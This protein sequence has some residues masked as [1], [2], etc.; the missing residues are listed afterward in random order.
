[1]STARTDRPLPHSLRKHLRLEKARLRRELPPEAAQRAIE[2]LERSLRRAGE[3]KA[4][5]R[6][7]E[8]S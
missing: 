7:D 3:A 4:K 1:M 2:Q 5:P 6:S 8:P